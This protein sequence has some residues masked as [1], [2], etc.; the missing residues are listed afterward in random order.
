MPKSKC[1]PSY[2]SESS[3]E[4]EEP[5]LK[6]LVIV[7]ENANP[8]LIL[9]S[10]DFANF[11]NKWTYF[12]NYHGVSHPSLPNYLSMIGGSTFGVTTDT[13]VNLPDTNLVDLLEAK[14]LTW[15]AY[16]ENLPST[17]FTGTISQP[18]LF[19][20]A[21][22]A[23][24]LNATCSSSFCFEYP[25]ACKHNPF[26]NFT[27]ITSN[28]ERLKNIVNAREF[29]KDIVDGTLPD[30]AY[31]VP[32]QAN[33][34][35]NTFLTL[36]NP[37]QCSNVQFN[38]DYAGNAFANTFTVPFATCSLLKNRVIAV[39]CDEGD[40]PTNNGNQTFA[41][42]AGLNV[43]K[44]NVVNTN[45]NHYNLLRTIE[46]TMHLG[47]LGR[48]DTLATP[49]TGWMKCGK[50][51]DSDHGNSISPQES[52]IGKH[53]VPIDEILDHNKD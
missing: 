6:W 21:N 27:D 18:T 39:V 5:I 28:P 25:Y 49:M 34:S 14:G 37:S 42:F 3:S 23:P 22:N 45:Y 12:S 9:S 36:S 31:Y 52:T 11:A 44:H 8:E 16:M 33:D 50:S 40:F 13:C 19:T 4:C 53:S 1:K 15:K 10:P 47:T 41:A 35:H 30:F 20:G 24:C 7:Y 43:K 29:F 51:N 2:H 46:N 26:V 38:Y 17:G 48:N 32:N